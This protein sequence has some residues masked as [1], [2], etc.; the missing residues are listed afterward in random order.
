MDDQAHRHRVEPALAEGQVVGLREL[1][2]GSAHAPLARLGEH[3]LRGVDAPG[4]HA[5][6]LDGRRDQR[7]RAAADVEQP[8][9][10]AEALRDR[11]LELR[12]ELLLRRAQLVVALRHAIEDRRRRAPSASV[13][14]VVVLV[15]V[16]QGLLRRADELRFDEHAAR[17]VVRRPAEL[18]LGALEPRGDAGPGQRAQDRVGLCAIARDGDRHQSVASWGLLLFRMR[19]PAPQLRR[20]ALRQRE[21]DGIEIARHDRGRRTPRAP[22]P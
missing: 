18:A 19:A 11:E 20:S 6:A 21:L 4:P 10:R 7:A 15:L 5:Q 22:R 13:V 8:R 12:S 9:G 1:E 3:R 16:E 2:R 14:V 17:A